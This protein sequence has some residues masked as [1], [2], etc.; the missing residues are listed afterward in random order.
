VERSS[1]VT[2]GASLETVFTSSLLVAASFEL[3]ASDFISV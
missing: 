3:V 2:A 1:I